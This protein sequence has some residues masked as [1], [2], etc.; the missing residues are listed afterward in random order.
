MVLYDLLAPAYDPVLASIYE[1]FRERA[2]AKLPYLSGAAVLDLACGTGLNFPLL[3][4]RVG[5]R[6]KIIGVDLSSGMLARARLRSD[7]SNVANA[8][9]IQ[10]NG[11]ELSLAALKAYTGLT[12]VD[13]LVCSYGLTSMRD[14]KSA[15]W[16]SWSLLRPG[17]GCLIHDIDGQRRTWHV[18]GVEWATRSHF[19]SRVWEPLQGECIDFRMDYLDPSAHLFGGRLFVATGTKAKTTTTRPPPCPS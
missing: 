19:S 4:S 18:C 12:T 7:K 16:A 11:A 5:P 1:P 9:F 6:G 14:W 13:Y 15:F 2:F 10:M 17:G 3:A 8:T